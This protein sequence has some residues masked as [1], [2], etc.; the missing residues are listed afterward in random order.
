MQCFP[1]Y[2]FRA[3]KYVAKMEI[4]ANGT[5]RQS[6]ALVIL[7]IIKGD[8]EQQHKS[9]SA[10]GITENTNGNNMQQ[11]GLLTGLHQQNNITD[12]LIYSRYYY[13]YRHP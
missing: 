1:D 9:A 13:R 5:G 7:K 10:D 6:L 3:F 4:Q 12:Y 8:Y 11:Q 2:L